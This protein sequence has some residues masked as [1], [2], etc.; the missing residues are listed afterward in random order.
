M[1]VLFVG[2]S[3]LSIALGIFGQLD[4]PVYQQSIKAVALAAKKYNKAAC[5]LLQ[6]I[7]EYEMYFDLGYR[8]LACGGDASFV[9]S[10]ATQMAKQM[11]EKNK[12]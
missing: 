1:D 11:N 10:G 9:A 5:V 4:H 3:D 7:S 12:T 8:F 2:P 6:D